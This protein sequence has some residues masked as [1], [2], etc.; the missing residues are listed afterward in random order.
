MIFVR[1]VVVL[2]LAVM[3]AACGGPFRDA[4][5][6]GDQYEKAGMWDKAAVEYQAALKIKPGDTDVTIKLRQVALKQSGERLARGK[7][8][9]ARGEIEAGLAVIQQAAKLAPDNTDAQR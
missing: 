6:R 8:L 1:P 7:A 3:L 5:K 9:M 4:V 2:W